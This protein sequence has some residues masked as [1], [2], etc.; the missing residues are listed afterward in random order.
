MYNLP[1]S[2]TPPDTTPPTNRFYSWAGKIPWRRKWQ[3]IQYSCL[4]NSL[5]RGAW[6]ATIH[7]FTESNMTE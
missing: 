5:D 1:F 4:E 7:V 3:S 6:R 2:Q